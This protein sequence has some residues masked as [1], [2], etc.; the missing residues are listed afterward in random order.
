LGKP[1]AAGQDFAFVAIFPKASGDYE[2]LA[3]PAG[4]FV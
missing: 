1:K 4:G 3:M 2:R